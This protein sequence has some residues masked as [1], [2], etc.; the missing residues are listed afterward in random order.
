MEDV[1]ILYGNLVYFKAIWYILWPFGIF[2][3]HLVYFVTIWYILWP[4]G[5]F[6]GYLVYFSGFGMLYQG[7]SGNLE[8]VPQA[9]RGINI[10]THLLSGKNGD[11]GL[12]ERP[13]MNV[14]K[15]NYAGLCN[16]FDGM[17]C[18]L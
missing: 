18:L 15:I 10:K 7:K 2:C 1:A 17:P 12:A 3:D 14:L 5:I 16:R 8:E 4:F 6:Y 9:R 11:L 13:P